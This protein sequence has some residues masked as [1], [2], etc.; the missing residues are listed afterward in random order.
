M[1]DYIQHI[2]EVFPQI[3]FAVVI[4]IWFLTGAVK[5]IFKNRV[6]NI[7]Y[8]IICYTSPVLFGALWGVVS[9]KGILNGV[10]IGGFAG[11]SYQIIKPLIKKYLG[12]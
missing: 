4:A 7:V 3:D 12:G 11:F 10:I 5:K 2:N 8:D 6:S 9:G 1:I